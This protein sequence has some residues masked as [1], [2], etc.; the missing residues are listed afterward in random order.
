MITESQMKQALNVV[1]REVAQAVIQA[2][3][4]QTKENP[5]NTQFGIESGR[6]LPN[7]RLLITITDAAAMLSISKA[8]LYRL[9]LQGQVRTIQIGRSRRIPVS[10]LQEF[11]AHELEGSV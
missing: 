8:A 5:T 9:I 1:L 7:G 11:I 4:Q 2:L 6:Y 10:A 3:P